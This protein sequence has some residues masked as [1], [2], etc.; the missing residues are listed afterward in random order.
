MPPD[1]TVLPIKIINNKI[2]NNINTQ[3]KKKKTLSALSSTSSSP[4]YTPLTI[5]LN[6]SIQFITPDRYVFEDNEQIT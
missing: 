2:V 4:P 1:K 6:K 3:S 5:N